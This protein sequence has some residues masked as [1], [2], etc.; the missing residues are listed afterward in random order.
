MNLSPL[1]PLSLLYRPGSGHLSELV[2]QF[3]GRLGELVDMTI[4]DP[5]NPILGLSENERVH[6]ALFS[7]AKLD[8]ILEQC[9]KNNI[10]L[11]GL[12]DEGY[13]PLLREI[14]N[15]PVLLYVAGNIAALGEGLSLAIVGARDPSEYSVAVTVK[16]IRALKKSEVRWNI[17]SGFARGIDIAAHI[18]AVKNGLPTIAVKGCGLLNNYPRQNERFFDTVARNGALISEYPPD[19]AAKAPYFP[20]RNRI[21][22][23]MSVGTVVIEASEKSGSLVTANLATEFGRDVFCIPPHDIAAPRYFGNVNLLRD[24]A[25]ALFGIRDLI[26]ENVNTTLFVAEKYAEIREEPKRKKAKSNSLLDEKPKKTAVGLT[27]A[28][29][30]LLEEETPPDISTLEGGARTIAEI[31]T[32]RKETLSAEDISLL[33]DLDVLDI[34][35][36]LTDLEIGG[37]ITRNADGTYGIRS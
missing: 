13:P 4:K 21:I 31:I 24:G 18:A 2:R 30:Y 6:A 23:G 35:D 33:T 17:V 28:E 5:R 7:N 3:D 10:K 36:I 37:F 32:A 8:K 15:P 14:Y 11:L 25:A 9:A 27:A 19:E 26:F 20:V 16:L 34:I 12:F 22:A 29:K 1:L